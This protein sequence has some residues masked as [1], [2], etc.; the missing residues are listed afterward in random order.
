LFRRTVLHFDN[1]KTFVISA[2]ENS[3]RNVYVR[4]A[5]LNGK[6]YTK[7]WI[8]HSVIMQGGELRLTMGA[9]PNKEKGVKAEDFPYSF[10]TDKEAPKIK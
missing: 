10:S 7:N 3:E 4:S 2:P 5:L 9:E 1:G 8:G 6:V